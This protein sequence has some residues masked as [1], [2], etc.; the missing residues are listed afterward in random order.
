MRKI[1]ESEFAR[2]CE[3]ISADREAIIRYNPVG[4][5]EETL[6][7]MLLSVLVSYLSLDEQETPC[8]TGMPD[9]DTYRKAI[10]H[11]LAARNADF[12]AGPHIEKMLL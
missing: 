9:A 12:D 10:L 4:T 5:A 1:T 7:W 2:I 6:L 11:V 3:N 8:F